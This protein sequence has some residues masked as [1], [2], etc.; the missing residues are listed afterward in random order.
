M[1]T[2][3]RRTMPL[4]IWRTSPTSLYEHSDL[5]AGNIVSHHCR[6]DRHPPS[7]CGM[8]STNTSSSTSMHYQ[9]GSLKQDILELMFQR[10]SFR[11][12]HFYAR[13][14]CTGSLQHGPSWRDGVNSRLYKVSNVSLC[15]VAGSEDYA[16][17]QSIWKLNT[18]TYNEMQ[19]HKND[20]NNPDTLTSANKTITDYSCSL[21]HVF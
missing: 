7:L 6:E 2:C 11:H 3:H 17:F 13:Q 4:D 14:F 18:S 10:Q 8:G 15:G 9:H 1:D 20:D 21:W 19:V 12:D 16:C 5:S